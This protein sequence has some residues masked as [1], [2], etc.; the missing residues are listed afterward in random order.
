[1]CAV[2]VVVVVS[3]L[4][5][6]VIECIG[7]IATSFSWAI[8]QF[9]FPHCSIALPSFS[10]CVYVSC[11]ILFTYVDFCIF[12]GA[13]ASCWCY[14]FRYAI[15]VACLLDFV[16]FYVIDRRLTE[17]VL[18]SLYIFPFPIKSTVDPLAFSSTIINQTFAFIWIVIWITFCACC[19]FS[20]FQLFVCF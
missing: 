3:L 20:S 5:I 17:A 12:N 10:L 6:I 13:S 19:L 8:F 15:L 14:L 7:R 11:G 16:W 4:L 2:I 18:F 9:L 1:M